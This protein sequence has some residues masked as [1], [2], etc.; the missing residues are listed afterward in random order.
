MSNHLIVFL[1]KVIV[2][3]HIYIYLF[4]RGCQAGASNLLPGVAVPGG[5]LLPGVA[6]PGG[7]LSAILLECILL[8]A[9]LLE[10]MIHS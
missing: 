8:L 9:S 1:V 10:G 6:V 3:I 4:G 2:I 7:V 5:R